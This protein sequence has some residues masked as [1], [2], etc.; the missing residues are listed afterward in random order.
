M[1]SGLSAAR[2]NQMIGKESTEGMFSQRKK[3]GFL[4]FRRNEFLDANGKALSTAEARS[5]GL[6]RY[7][8]GQGAQMGAMMAG[9][10]AGMGLM[11]QG[12]SGLGMG[13]MMGSMF[14][15]QIIS[16]S[17]NGLKSFPGHIEAIS[18]ALKGTQGSAKEIGRAHV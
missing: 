12:H 8:M 18:T 1:A 10:V 13:V 3:S 15:P 16:K 11:Q 7:Q 4:G 5:L 6:G 9:Q 17:V 14:A 2:V